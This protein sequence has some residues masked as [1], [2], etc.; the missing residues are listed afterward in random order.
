VTYC[1]GIQVNEGL[2]MV[3]DSRTNAGVDQVST[4]SKMW[5]VGIPGERQFMISSAGNLATTQAVLNEV[6]RHA[7]ER[8][9]TSLMTVSSLTQAADYLGAL[10]VQ[11]QRKHA[12]QSKDPAG[13][14]M[15]SSSF[16]I[17]GEVENSECGL[18]MVYPE[19]NYIATSTQAPFLQIGEIKY[20]KPILDR[21]IS[22]H[23]HINH[24][25]LCALVSMDATMRSNLTV[26]P[27]I[28]LAIYRAGSLQ[29]PQYISFSED[30]AYL[31]ELGKT[32]NKYME[33]A[34]AK[35][36]PIPLSEESS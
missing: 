27:P 24:A 32:W 30:S 20:G 17:A 16:I 14:Q 36:P 10:S 26:G 31:R 22:G 2:V 4:Y 29:P 23:T 5:T 3:S 18:Y 13:G 25:A 12:E 34:F 8:A 33:E 35:L 1:V 7:R 21:V 11:E 19:G 15:F 28:E 6:K 9:E